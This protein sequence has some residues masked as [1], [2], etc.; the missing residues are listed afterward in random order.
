MLEKNPR[1]QSHRTF[2]SNTQGII[3]KA[4]DEHG[5]L[6]RGNSYARKGTLLG[7]LE[8]PRT[9]LYENLEKLEK[10]KIVERFEKNNGKRG[11]PHVFWRIK[12]GFKR[13]E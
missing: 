1:I 2:L 9:T 8:I 13:D 11:R 3:I 7:I 10:K 4:L 5:P 12:E 6:K